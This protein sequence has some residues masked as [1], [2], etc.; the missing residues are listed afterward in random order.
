LAEKEKE[1]YIQSE[2]GDEDLYMSCKRETGEKELEL[3]SG[4]FFTYKRR[5][6]K[7]GGFIEETAS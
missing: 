1:T 5:G 2:N 6:K 4:A 3:A 7:R